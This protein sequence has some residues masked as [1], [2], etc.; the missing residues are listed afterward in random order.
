MRVTACVVPASRYAVMVT[1]ST[2]NPCT[3]H[4]P[5]RL[6]E[7]ACL[8]TSLASSDPPEFFRRLVAM[9]HLHF[10]AA[11]DG[12]LD[13]LGRNRSSTPRSGAQVGWK[14]FFLAG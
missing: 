9:L 14:I 12:L 1:L 3:H 10:G 2:F 13:T 4:P 8:C 6:Q 11:R 5:A 7:I